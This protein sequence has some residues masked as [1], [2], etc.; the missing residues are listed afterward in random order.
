M[1][2]LAFSNPAEFEERFTDE[3]SVL[4]LLHSNCDPEKII[5]EETCTIRLIVSHLPPQLGG[6]VFSD[7]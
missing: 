6:E 5:P 1:Y 3:T 7:G 2:F 4:Y